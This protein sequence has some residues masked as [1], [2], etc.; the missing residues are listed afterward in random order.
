MPARPWRGSRGLTCAPAK[1]VTDTARL[2]ACA[3]ALACLTANQARAQVAGSISLATNELFRG[4]TVTGDAPAI[5]AGLSLDGPGG[6]FAGASA[7]VTSGDGDLRV[8]AVTQ[9]IGYAVRAGDVSVEAGVIHRSYARI[10]DRD[11]RRGF[12][13]GYLGA[14]RKGVKLR[15][16]VSPDYLRDGQATYYAEVNARLLQLSKWSLDGH[17][18]LSLIPYDKSGPGGLHKYRD[19]R[20]QVSRPAGRLYLSAGVAA[21]NYPVYDASGKARVFASAS[22]AF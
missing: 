18:G 11:Y 2:L 19:W 20:L 16:Y 10:V 4:E 9:Y 21:T 12:F 13:E 6:F 17:A 3:A 15:V 22:F 7:T 14:S 5:S 8:A 1:P